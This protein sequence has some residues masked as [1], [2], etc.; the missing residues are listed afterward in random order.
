LHERPVDSAQVRE[1]LTAMV[2]AFNSPNE[3]PEK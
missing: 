2:L 3:V 1:T